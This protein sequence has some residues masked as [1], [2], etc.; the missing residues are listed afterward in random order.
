MTKIC[1]ETF[2][3]SNSQAEAEIMAGLLKEAGFEIVD[4]K[5]AELVIFV[6]CYVKNPTEQ[7][8]FFRIKELYQ[9]KKIIIAGC[10]PEGIYGRLKR[11]FPGV[12]MLSTHHVKEVVEAVRKTL[13]G[14]TVEYLGK[15]DEIKL[16]L[17]KIR[18]NPVIDIVPISSGCNSK[19]HYCCV[20]L[21][22][23][24]LFSY[25]SDMIVK[26]IESSLKEGCREILLT[27]QDTASYGQDRKE[28]LPQ[29]LGKI[30]KIQGKFSV[31]VGMMNIKNALP[32]ASEIVEAFKSNKFYKFIHLPIQSGSDQV[33]ASM[34]RGYTAGQFEDIVKSFKGCQLW[35]DVIVGYPTES[36]DDFQK[37]LGVIKRT[38]PDWV[39]VSKYG[40]RAGTEAAKMKTLPPK[41]VNERSRILSELA[42]KISLEKNERWM[43]WKGEILISEGGSKKNQWK[44][45]NFEYKPVL[46]ESENDLL[47]KFVD[48][49]VVKA[50]RFHLEGTAI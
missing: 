3:C 13:D 4:N 22:K 1:I 37:T 20:R 36:E 38:R 25:P 39:N 6:T 32:I 30:S 35:T 31:R 21:A 29:L 17:P 24:R 44:G 19:C 50:N 8:I 23:G 7:K 42:R 16:C 18:K 27:A 5:G 15:S 41:V 11:N 2:G 26:E 40:P 43:D 49:R 47:G 46:I 10:M 9:K 33:L 12:S 45:R 34:N 14:K 28:S 48:V